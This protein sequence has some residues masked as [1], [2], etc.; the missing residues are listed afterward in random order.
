VINY[1]PVSDLIAGMEEA[2]EDY[3]KWDSCR[4]G[5]NRAICRSSKKTDYSAA[6]LHLDVYLFLDV[7]GYLRCDIQAA[8]Q[9][10]YL[11]V[12]VLSSASRVK[13]DS[14]LQVEGCIL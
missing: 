13:L 7:H 9:P 10:S 12:G 2:R 3:K 8:V 1:S 5:R 6:M 14:F 4:G 11:Y